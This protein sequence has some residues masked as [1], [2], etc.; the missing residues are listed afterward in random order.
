MVSQMDALGNMT[1]HTFDETGNLISI[2][3]ANGNTTNYQYDSNNRTIKETYADRTM[4][5]YVYDDFGNVISRENNNGIITTYG[6]DKR[7]RLLLKS[8][9]GNNN[10]YF[11]YDAVGRMTSAS[12]FDAIVLFSYDM[13][14]RL[15]YESL[16]GDTTI[17]SYDIPNREKTIMYSGGNHNVTETYDRRGRLK[18]LERN[19]VVIA[20][21][22][23]DGADRTMSRNYSN[24][25]TSHFNYNNTNWVTS[26]QHANN[27]GNF[28]HLNYGF[29][30]EGN[31]QYEDHM[32]RPDFRDEKYTYEDNYR[33]TRFQRGDPANGFISNQ[34]SYDYDPLGNRQRM[35]VNDSSTTYISNEM[36]EYTSISGQSDPVYDHNGNLINGEN[37]TYQYDIE[38]R[39]TSVNGGAIATYRYDPLGRRISKTTSS[40]TTNYVYDGDKVIEEWEGS[41]TLRTRY[42]YGTW[43]DDIL[44]MQR[45]GDYFYH[46]NSLGSVV[47]LTNSS[48]IPNEFYEY[49]AFGKVNRVDQVIYSEDKINRLQTSSI[50]NPYF[51]TSR[52][53]DEESGL[54]YYRARYLDSKMGRFLSRD[55]YPRFGVNL[56]SYVR[57]R[58]TYYIDPSGL[59]EEPPIPWSR[60][61]PL[62]PSDFKGN[63][64]QN[65]AFDARTA[66][67]IVLS[68]Y[69]IKVRC[70]GESLYC[71]KAWYNKIKYEVLFYPSKS[72]NT[73][74]DN[75][76]LL[77]HEQ[78]HFD[79]AAIHA[80][81]LTDLAR[82]LIGWGNNA[83]TA[84]RDLKK[85]NLELYKRWRKYESDEQDLYDSAAQTD[86]G[87]NDQIQERW[88]NKNRKL[89]D[90]VIKSLLQ[91]IPGWH[92]E[93]RGN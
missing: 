70:N 13:T 55:L 31:K 66:Y 9:P 88:D 38:N 15:L 51:F 17:N 89:L 10:E 61:R 58:P 5:I 75:E 63:R 37:F 7:N 36:N 82:L 18:Q 27:T 24:G 8:Y 14:G 52:R 78:G 84:K 69:E 56:Y 34:I 46:K 92:L 67:G 79:I 68:N 80:G 86:H 29:D 28:I 25:T 90:K 72:F 6:Y 16:N 30:A 74:P 83:R 53:L 39:L 50:G 81:I 3:D 21:W 19:G 1:N 93:A 26:L 47:A 76:L 77:R 23:Y 62:R 49:D 40:G 57:S 45:E 48:G 35:I 73:L 43:I 32:H 71:C 54:Y 2:I 33:L 85:R 22:F 11:V 60:G 59:Q 65:S 64:P 42:L 12:N 41:E 87:R 4:K 20:S 44:V 91:P